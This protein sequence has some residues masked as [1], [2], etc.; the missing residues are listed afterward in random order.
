MSNN[1]LNSQM[2][3]KFENDILECMPPNDW[4]AK[5]NEINDSYT[6]YLLRDQNYIGNTDTANLVECLKILRDFFIDISEFQN[7]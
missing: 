2:L 1:R 4:V 5:I 6:Q 7:Q 3:V